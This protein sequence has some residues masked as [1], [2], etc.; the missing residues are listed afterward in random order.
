VASGLTQPHTDNLPKILTIVSVMKKWK[1][2]EYRINKAK[3]AAQ[4]TLWKR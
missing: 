4:E 2:V 3:V 1:I